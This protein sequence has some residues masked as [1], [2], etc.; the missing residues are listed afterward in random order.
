MGNTEPSLSVLY[1][2]KYIVSNDGTVIRTDA[3]RAYSTKT[4]GGYMRLTDG[5][6][7]HRLIYTLFVG[8]IPA[9]CVINHI[10][11]NKENNAVSNLE[12]VT[13][14]ENMRHA[15]NVIKSGNYLV[16]RKL[17]DEDVLDIVKTLR[18]TD[19]RIVDIALKY[20]VSENAICRINA[21]QNYTRLTLGRC[22]DYPIRSKGLVTLKRGTL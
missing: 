18:D 22:N 3:K 6:S 7:L 16:H 15:A 2:D 9:K 10:D 1:K 13:Y 21:G 17:T 4:N 14:Q 12:A 19:E 8:A 20:S 11:G 5:T